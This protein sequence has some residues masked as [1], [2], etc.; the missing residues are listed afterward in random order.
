MLKFFKTAIFAVAIAMLSATATF[1]QTNG[2]DI[3]AT[4]LG[5]TGLGIKAQ[6][7]IPTNLDREIVTAKATLTWHDEHGSC[8]TQTQDGVPT[9]FPGKFEFGFWTPC[10]A[11]PTSPLYVTYVIEGMNG[12]K[13]FGW[14]T[15]GTHQVQGYNDVLYITTWQYQIVTPPPPPGG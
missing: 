9:E 10:V 6:F 1:A 12:G 13:T 14:G 7:P 5:G 15:S 8:G 3:G 11:S 2:F 4:N